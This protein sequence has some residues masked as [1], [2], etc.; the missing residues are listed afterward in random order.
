MSSQPVGRERFRLENDTLYAVIAAVGSSADLDR[1]LRAMVEL[2]TEATD[3]H[4]CFV[5]LRHG[6]RLRM[7]AA[8]RVYAHLVGRVELGLDESLSGWVARHNVPAFIRENALADSRMQYVPELEEERFESICAVPVPARS[9]EVLGTIVLHTAAPREF[10]EG[11]LSFLSH[12]ASLVAGVI[13]NARLLEESR[14]QVDTLTGLAGLSQSVAAATRREDL[15]RVA[16]ANVRALL[17]ADTCRLYRLDAERGELEAAAADPPDENAPLEGAIA[18]V[19]LEVLRRPGRAPSATAPGE[20]GNGPSLLAA[21][22]VVG[23]EDLGVL[24]VASAERD[25]FGDEEDRLLRTAASQVALALKKTELIERLTAE[26]VTRDMFNALA[27]GAGAV[28]EAR[29]RAAGYDLAKRHV[30]LHITP[31][32]PERA[33]REWPMLA[34][35][36]ES[37]L[38][39]TACGA[40]CDSGPQ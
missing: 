3:C 16:T 28:A 1:V 32:E 26:N 7:R 5:Y 17:R 23:D 37:R 13:E 19:L 29:A 8:S 20:H 18:A 35:R 31:A 2:L 11:V 33:E 40:V 27:A 14:R 34:E 4:A 24:I 10:E 12:T 25:A 6:E 22:L 38:R 21:P 30:V 39:R 9:G 15:Y 36:I